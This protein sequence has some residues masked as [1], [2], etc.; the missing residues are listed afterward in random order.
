MFE[1]FSGNLG[2]SFVSAGTAQFLPFPTGV[3]WIRVQNQTVSYVGGAGT[4]AEFFW[5]K[6]MTDGRGTIYVKTAGN[7]ALQVGQIAA[8]AGFFYQDTTIN[9][10][11]ARVALTG[12]TGANPPVVNTGSTAG[13]IANSTIVR[14]FNT[15]G[16]TQLGGIDFTVGTVVAN[17]SFTL[18][19]M[20]AI[21]AANPGAGSYRIIP[22]NPYFYPSIRTITKISQANP[23]IVTLSVTHNY[24]VGMQVK[25]VVPTV[26]A[27]AF[28]MTQLNEVVAT[29]INVGQADADGVT[30]TITV[31]V[32]T[33]AFTAFAWPL[34]GAPGFTPP[35]VVPV[36]ENTAYANNPVLSVPQPF[37][38]VNPYL[39][40]T[41]NTGAV[42]L[43]LQAGTL[44]PAGVATNIISWQA[45]KCW[46]Q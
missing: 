5:R 13:L 1:V 35:Q 14:I 22:Y 44:S 9:N 34:T 42:G 21:A 8:N 18:A 26:T 36:S 28:G 25:F 20:A 41:L 43:L 4:G 46:N 12:I 17:T 3:D 11:G 2:G 31:D 38:P 19:Y 16:A 23:A 15:V 39:D 30:N 32:D 10:P 40:S 7:N 37:A 27:V 6:G 24:Q 29:I 33:T 45:G